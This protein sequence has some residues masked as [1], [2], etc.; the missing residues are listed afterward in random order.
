MQRIGARWA[1]IGRL[2]QQLSQLDKAVADLIS[3]RDR[4]IRSTSWRITAPLR[5]LKTGWQ[6]WVGANLK[7]ALG[8]AKAHSTLAELRPPPVN[9]DSG[10]PH[11]LAEPGQGRED[12]R[13]WLRHDLGV[14]DQSRIVLVHGEP[15]DEAAA[16]CFVQAAKACVATRNDVCFVMLG[17]RLEA[18]CWV[19][20]QEALKVL[21]STRRLFFVPAISRLGDC[22][23]A[24]DVLLTI[25]EIA[26][27]SREV[28]LAEGQGL[29]V[30]AAKDVCAAGP[31]AMVQSLSCLLDGAIHAR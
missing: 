19:G 7:V 29:S 15:S 11:D 20:I 12:A 9:R 18:A 26:E 21:S 17:T 5:A 31:D 23:L 4:L 13:R 6:R 1:E 16:D 14:P 3:E 2:H 22:L 28:R 8:D 25:G 30:M 10:L 27:T 24:A